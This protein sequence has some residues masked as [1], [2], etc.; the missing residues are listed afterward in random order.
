MPG[1]RPY[2]RNRMIGKAPPPRR[3]LRLKI[4]LAVYVLAAA[5][6]PLTHH[7][8]VCHAKSSNH[9]STCTIGSSGEAAADPSDVARLG[10]MKAGEAIAL[11]QVPVLAPVSSA[12]SGRAP[13][14]SCS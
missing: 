10:L 4:V 3:G 7:D 6:L 5:L 12:C 8:V 9:C 1:R 14:A 13:P 2:N 11:C